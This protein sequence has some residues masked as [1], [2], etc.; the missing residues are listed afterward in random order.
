MRI[1]P[2]LAVLFLTISPFAFA[3][4]VIE[5]ES[6]DGAI[7]C[8]QREVGPSAMVVAT[9]THVINPH[10]NPGLTLLLRATSQLEKYPEAKA[11]FE[12]AAAR[13]ESF[14]ANPITVA[15]DVDYGPQLFGQPFSAHQLGATYP[16]MVGQ[17]YSSFVEALKASATQPFETELYAH[18]PQTPV[19]TDIV[20]I[21][22]VND[23]GAVLTAL[24][25]LP[26]L[27]EPPSIGRIGFNSAFK[28]DFDRSDGLTE[29]DFETIALHEIGH[30]L[31]FVSSV[32]VFQAGIGVTPPIDALDLFR[33]RPGGSLA[34]FAT[35]NRI[36]TTGGDQVLFTGSDDVPLS[37]AAPDGSGGDGRQASHWK[38][39]FLVGSSLGVMN[40]GPADLFSPT[41]W[42]LMALDLI[43]YTI[44]YPSPPE[45]A[46]TNLR[47]FAI[48]ASDMLLTWEDN[49]TNESEFRLRV[50]VDGY[51]Q[52]A[53]EW[54]SIPANATSF[55]MSR[56][57]SNIKYHFAL[58]AMNAGG[59]SDYS[60]EA[61]A[62]TAPPYGPPRRRAATH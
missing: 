4:S 33:L 37:T 11:A 5:L 43:G 23:S 52:S 21:Y 59:W 35:D 46:P 3:D 15:L 60:N 56:Q 18:L 54:P 30:A 38:D 62:T 29:F 25:L 57:T 39:Q 24:G 16:W 58:R 27:Q 8:T 45:A 7:V 13:W 36:Q 50:W 10:A 22:S 42:D 53:I 19:P 17:R 61:T 49:S 32:G 55:V 14:I 28:F 34:N 12:R 51:E 31:G 40:P 44:N 6:V 41:K 9:P 48:S 47:A 20:P 26:T 2:T 1:R